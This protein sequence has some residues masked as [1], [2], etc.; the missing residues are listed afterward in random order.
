MLFDL[1]PIA[2]AFG[3]YEIGLVVCLILGFGI[4]IISAMFG[5]GGGFIITP[6]FHAGVGLSASHSVASSTGQ[7]PL[8]AA[9]ACWDYY[10][11]KLIAFKASLVFLLTAVPSAQIIAYYVV[12]FETSDWGSNIVWRTH[13]KADLIVI[14]AYIIIIGILGIYNVYKSLKLN[15]NDESIEPLYKGKKLEWV[16][17]IS[18]IIFGASAALLG[19]GGGFLAVPFFI[20]VHGLKPVNAIATSMF[21][22]LVTSTIT[23]LQYL[24]SGEI[25]FGLSLI[26]ALGSIVGVKIGT[27]MAVKLPSHILFRLFAAFQLIV[28]VIYMALK[29]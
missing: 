17:A 8:M 18:G 24:W 5:I 12:Y 9:M 13:T 22:I 15:K 19:I 6:F 2:E 27:R 16:N 28:V 29:I 14:I 26:I 25:F 23:T 21:C 1:T 11:K 10:K 7:I 4:G 20:Y 3:S